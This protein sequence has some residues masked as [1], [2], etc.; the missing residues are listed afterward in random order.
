[1]EEHTKK[2]G[3]IILAAG[4][5]KRMQSK[6]INKV[7]LPLA[8]KPLILHAIHVL[9]KMHFNAIVIVVGFAKESVKQ[10]L[11]N[12][13]VF[14]AEQT[15]RLG[16]GHAVKAGMTKIPNDITDVLVMQ[17]D[18]SHFY[19]ETMINKLIT[20]HIDAHAQLTFLTIAV[21]NPY[22]LGRV[23]R[24]VHKEVVAI[25]EEKDA[26]QKQKEVKEINPACYIFTESF[27][28]KYLSK[29]PKSPVT[30]EYYLTSLID[31]AIKNKEKVATMQAGF[32]PWRG[33]NTPEELQEAEKLYKRMQKKV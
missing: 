29:I 13:S 28:K 9:E 32:M 23:I 6:K 5:G 4:K 12:S 18:D 27:L 10:I 21:E 22:G 33:V 7:T 30:G 25:I 2:L 3:A 11:K 14:F 31:I 17:G 8:D 1:M 16:T 26:T 20:A 15:K 24:D 19:Q